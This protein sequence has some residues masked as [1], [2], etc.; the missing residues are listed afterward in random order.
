LLDR[1]LQALHGDTSNAES[2]AR[3]LKHTSIPNAPRGPIAF[4]NLGNPVQ[5]IYIRKV[6][7]GGGAIRNA[8]IATY[9]HVSQFWTFNPDE[10]L[11]H[12]VY[13]RTYPACNAC[14]G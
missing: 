1:A 4:D 6:E 9:P 8:V 14:G 7:G 5:N 13:S 10:F 2:F 3:T 11:K 12:P